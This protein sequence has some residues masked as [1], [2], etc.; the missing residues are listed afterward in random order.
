M[1]AVTNPIQ[2]YD[3][4]RRKKVALEPIDAT[5][6]RMYACGPTVY[7]HAHI[8]NARPVIVFDVLFRLLRYT[9]GADHVTYA[10]NI[11]DVDDKINAR[12]AEEYPKLPLNDAI[13]E[14]TSRT[15][16]RYHA[17]IRE[18]GVLEP[19]I[20]PRCTA[21]V[22]QMVAMIETLIEKGFAYEA[23]GHALLDTNSVPEYGQLSGRSLDEMIAGARVEVAPYKRNPSDSVLW[24]PSTDA[25]PGWDSPWGRGRPGWHIEC[26]AMAAE[27]LGDVFDIHGGGIDL[28]FPHHENELAQSRCAHGTDGMANIWM[29]N[30]YLQVEGE[31]MSKS[32]GNFITITE[33]LESHNF[34]GRKWPGEVLR[35][36]MLM[37]HYR[38]P[39]DFTMN[40][41]EAAEKILDGWYRMIGDVAA[42]PTSD[43]EIKL[44]TDALGDDLNSPKAI[45]L[46]H[47]FSDDVRTGAGD[48]AGSFKRAANLIGLLTMT[49]SEW[50][51]LQRADM[52]IDEAQIAALIQERLDARAAKNFARS[53]EIRDQLAADGVQLKDGKDPA[54]GEPITTWQVKR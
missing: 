26:S 1:S 46:L 25:Q 27:H 17:D 44:A 49:A 43:F 32:T 47:S 20:E 24:K 33:L 51:A 42:P 13:A 23:E 19:T 39:I 52:S 40:T 16:A 38:Q 34:G 37:T 3:T 8:G 22:P 29:H 50:N 48:A 5:N 28:T 15:T 7:D 6:V 45:T 4:L 12:A 18:L 53:D 30:G 21:H 2:L 35:L 41:L 11:T 10:R 9:F 54:T 31:K 36:A 14:V